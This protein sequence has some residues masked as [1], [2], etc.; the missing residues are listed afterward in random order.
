[1][2]IENFNVKWHLDKYPA[3]HIL[4]VK[5]PDDVVGGINKYIDEQLI[6]YDSNFGKNKGNI[7]V[8]NSYAEAL[9][10]Q[11][12]QDKKSA[13]LEYN[14]FETS[15]GRKLKALLD[16]M[17]NMY[18]KEINFGDCLADVFESWTIHSYE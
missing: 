13:Q 15:D 12:R 16:Q 6:P 9:V 14:L 18:L 5:L 11:I 10:G 3:I 1:M 2:S 17:S 4:R 7:E 8:E